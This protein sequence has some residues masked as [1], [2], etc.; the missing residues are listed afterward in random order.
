MKF[1]P[2][3]S[4]KKKMVVILQKDSYSH[5]VYVKGASE[6][7]LEECVNYVFKDEIE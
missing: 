2:F 5:L 1:I 3:N 4:D 6:I 7:V